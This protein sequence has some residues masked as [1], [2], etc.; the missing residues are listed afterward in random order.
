MMMG[1]VVSGFFH[2]VV[3]Y[4]ASSLHRKRQALREVGGYKGATSIATATAL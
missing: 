4:F 3:I 2:L 1:L